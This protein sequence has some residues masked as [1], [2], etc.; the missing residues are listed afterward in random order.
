MSRPRTGMAAITPAPVL[1]PILDKRTA[2]LRVG[3]RSVLLWALPGA[4][5]SLFIGERRCLE[6]WR[7]ARQRRH[8][9][10]SVGAGLDLR[11]H[12][13]PRPEGDSAARSAG[14][15]DERIRLGI[16]C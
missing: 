13:W 3:L 16:G 9:R 12:G 15:L 1:P 8:Q 2:S 7:H 5:F 11:G 10:I 14:D 4:G 6:G